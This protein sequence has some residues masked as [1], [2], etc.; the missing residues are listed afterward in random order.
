MTIDYRPE[1]VPPAQRTADDFLKRL[2]VSLQPGKV[3]IWI[4]SQEHNEVK[5]H[6][7]HLA[8]DPVTVLRFVPGL[9]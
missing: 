1:N 5:R 4:G 3:G 7:A 9:L 2:R 8:F 6:K